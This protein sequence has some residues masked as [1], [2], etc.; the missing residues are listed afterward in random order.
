MPEGSKTPEQP[1]SFPPVPCGR[2]TSWAHDPPSRFLPHL[3]IT[4]A[5]RNTITTTSTTEVSQSP[6]L[7]WG[8]PPPSPL[9]APSRK[10]GHKHDHPEKSTAKGAKTNQNPIP[11]ARPSIRA[12]GQ[13]GPSP[14]ADRD[15][16][17][18]WA[19]PAEQCFH[20]SSCIVK[21][22]ALGGAALVPCTTSHICSV[23]PHSSTPGRRN[24]PAATVRSNQRS[25]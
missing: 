7:K 9:L 8:P 13:R 5:K 25:L 23:A 14:Q 20:C 17:V 1:P 12:H 16:G 6:S 3:H 4:C 21:Q 22:E 10:R 2:H 11:A 19:P 18:P 15:T 24:R